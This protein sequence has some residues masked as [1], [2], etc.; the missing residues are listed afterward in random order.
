MKLLVSLVVGLIGGGLGL[1]VGAGVSAVLI[2]W[3][4]LAA[5]FSVWIWWTVWGLDPTSTAG[6]ARREDPGREVADLVLVVAALASLV[7][8]GVVLV[9][10]GH[11]HGAARYLRAGFAVASVVVSWIL[12]HT[13]FALKYARLYYSGE[14]GG[15]EFNEEDEPQYTDFAYLAFTI[16]MTFQVSDTNLKTKE[17]RRTALHHAWLS[18]PLGTVIIAASINLIAGLAP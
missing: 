15:I 1:V 6:H 18:F 2:A 11:A 14:A 16:G 12:V 7:A 9:S 10:A 3:D 8:V 4:V 17:I 13:V 5:V